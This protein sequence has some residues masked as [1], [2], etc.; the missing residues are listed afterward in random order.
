MAGMAETSTKVTK[1]GIAKTLELWHVW[2]ARAVR[3]KCSKNP[4]ASAEDNRAVQPED[5]PLQW[6]GILPF[7]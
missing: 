4:K 7:S 2:Q 6:T 5:A 3:L 1:Q